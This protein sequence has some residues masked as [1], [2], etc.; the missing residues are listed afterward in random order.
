MPLAHHF[1]AQQ[2]PGLRFSSE[3]AEKLRGYGW[4]G[5]VRELKNVAV[6]AAVFA[7]GPEVATADLPEEFL[8]D[9]FSAGLY[10]CVVLPE[11]EKSAILEALRENGGHQERAAAGLGISRRTLQRRMKTYQ[12]QGAQTAPLAG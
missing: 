5:N 2:R 12:N 3:A 10:R 7:A 1:L 8:Q 11:L 4:S 9:A 6:R